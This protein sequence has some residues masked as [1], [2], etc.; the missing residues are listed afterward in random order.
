[1]SKPVS[2]TVALGSGNSIN[3]YD[4]MSGSL[5]KTVTLAGNS[6]IISGPVIF[7]EGFSLTVKE[8]NTTYM[9][10]YGF[11]LCNI[12]TRTQVASN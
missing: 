9:L 6:S 12:R 11:P 1:M 5:Y 10:T 7:G 3:I 8:G 4:A 2:F